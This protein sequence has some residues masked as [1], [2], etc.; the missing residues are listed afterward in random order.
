MR[1]D[2]QFGFPMTATRRPLVVDA[3]ASWLDFENNNV[4]GGI[5]KDLR[6]ELGAFVVRSDGKV[7]ADVGMHDDNV[8]SAALFVYVA[9]EHSPKATPDPIDEPANFQ[10]A[11]SVN[12][13]WEEAEEV[14]R[15]QDIQNRKT[16]LRGRRRLG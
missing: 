7:A 11:A 12:H 6:R 4:M 14:W 15:M 5:D 13:I 8:M 9:Q 1:H 16:F 10:F 2:T 3:L